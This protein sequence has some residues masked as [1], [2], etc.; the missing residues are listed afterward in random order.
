MND[1]VKDEATEA[2]HCNDLKNNNTWLVVAKNFYEWDKKVNTPITLSMTKPNPTLTNHATS[3]AT[4]PQL[5]QQH[6][7]YASSESSQ[8]SEG[9]ESTTHVRFLDKVVD[10][11]A[12][13]GH[14]RPSAPRMFNMTMKWYTQHAAFQDKWPSDSLLV[15]TD[16]FFSQIVTFCTIL[17]TLS[18]HSVSRHCMSH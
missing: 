11:P 17:D 3:P 13:N 6:A 10:G 14:P 8:V 1:F 18:S 2:T 16:L 15:C 5:Q 12:M 7:R 4:T 9:A